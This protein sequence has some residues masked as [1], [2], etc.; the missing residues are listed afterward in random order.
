MIKSIF[1]E[2]SSKMDLYYKEIV[3]IMILRSEK[4]IEEHEQILSCIKY[5]R[6]SG[7]QVGLSE[8]IECLHLKRVIQ[9]KEIELKPLKN[10]FNY[11]I[12]QNQY[13]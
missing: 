3:Q 2:I 1:L 10:I 9:H 11:F 5:C 6:R 7:I 4:N 12:K 13:R 8:L